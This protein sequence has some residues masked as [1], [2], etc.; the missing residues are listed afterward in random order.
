ML[1]DIGL[2]FDENG[3]I[4]AVV[5]D[6]ENGDVLMVAYMNAEAVKLTLETGKATFY[7]RSRDKMWIKGEES[8]HTQIVKSVRTDCDKDTLVVRVKQI[9]GACHHGY[10]SCFYREIDADGN[11]TVIAERIFDPDEVYGKSE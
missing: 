10:R 6:D 1:D 2:K 11:L 3:L 9:G 5:Q 4:P 8:G 7:S